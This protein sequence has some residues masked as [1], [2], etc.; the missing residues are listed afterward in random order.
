MINELLDEAKM[1]KGAT[2]AIGLDLTSGK[3]IGAA[4]ALIFDNLAVKKQFLHLGSIIATKLLL[5]DEVMRAGR[6][7]GK[8]R[9]GEDPVGHED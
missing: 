4:D 7:Q 3:P 1:T 2:D 6:P 5:V 9:H 8:D